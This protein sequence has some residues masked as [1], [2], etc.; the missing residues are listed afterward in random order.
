V[1]STA[2]CSWRLANALKA[3]YGTAVGV[4]RCRERSGKTEVLGLAHG[5]SDHTED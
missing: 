4:I 3:V 5:K 2:E 1:S